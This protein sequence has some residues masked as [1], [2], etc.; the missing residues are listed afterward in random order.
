LPRLLASIASAKT[1]NNVGKAAYIQW[2]EEQSRLL[3]S[4]DSDSSSSPLVVKYTAAQRGLPGSPRRNGMV[5]DASVRSIFSMRAACSPHNRR[6]NPDK[7][8]IC[9]VYHSPLQLS[10]ACWLT[11]LQRRHRTP[12]STPLPARGRNSYLHRCRTCPS[13]QQALWLPGRALRAPQAGSTAES[14]LLTVPPNPS[15]ACW[16][17]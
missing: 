3:D 8:Q 11:I 10:W 2:A 12:I 7:Y 9:G 14:F 15:G 1:M 16:P 4:G 17:R 5:L 13:S 6:Q